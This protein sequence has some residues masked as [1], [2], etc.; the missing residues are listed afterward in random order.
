MLSATSLLQAVQFLVFVVLFL[1]YLAVAVYHNDP[2]WTTAEMVAQPAG[3]AAVVLEVILVIMM[4]G[5]VS[6]KGCGLKL[7]GELMAWP[8]WCRMRDIWLWRWK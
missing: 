7:C 4:A 5:Q 8:L 6:H 3:Q 2:T 1:A